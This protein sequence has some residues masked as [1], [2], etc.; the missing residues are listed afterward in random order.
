MAHIIN[1]PPSDIYFTILGEERCATQ[2]LS[3]LDWPSQ[4]AITRRKRQFE[5]YQK[6]ILGDVFADFIRLQLGALDYQDERYD[7]YAFCLIFTPDNPFKNRTLAVNTIIAWWQRWVNE[8][9]YLQCQGS[10]S[11]GLTYLVSV[12]FTGSEARYWQSLLIVMFVTRY[13]L[14]PV[15]P[16][17]IYMP[18]YEDVLRI[19]SDAVVHWG[20]MPERFKSELGEKTGL[21]GIELQD[22]IDDYIYTGIMA[23]RLDLFVELLYQQQA[24]RNKN[25]AKF[26]TYLTLGMAALIALP[27]IITASQLAYSAVMSPSLGT[28]STLSKIKLGI[29]VFAGSLQLAFKGLLMAIHFDTLIKIHKVAWLVSEDYRIVMRGIYSELSAISQALGF[30]PYY[31]TLLLQNVRMLVLDVASTF[32]MKADL[33]E[34]QWLTTMQGYLGRFAKATTRYANNPEAIFFDLNRWVEKDLVDKKGEFMQGLILTVERATEA[35]GG[36]IENVVV[37]RNDIDRLVLDLPE[38][39]RSQVEPLVRPYLKEFDDFI[40]TTYDPYKKQLDN[41][42]SNVKAIQDQQVNNMGLLVDRLKKPGDYL[43][44]IDRLEPWE[45]VSQERKIGDIST[46]QYTRDVSELVEKGKPVS[47]ELAKIREALKLVTL[48]PLGF[49]EE[50][51]APIRSSK[52]KATPRKTWFIGDY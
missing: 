11:P 20:Q 32:G 15:L 6:G 14:G 19:N 28:L 42:I 38:N 50:I 22:K 17:G 1:D 48:V 51:E 39:I 23:L 44:E 26:R 5:Y 12:G 4:E 47:A 3:V 13:G 40:L 9:V 31:L 49:P 29:E 36:V 24:E 21:K 43:S 25:I 30:G 2:D 33:A 37:I 35:V 7:R 52:V 41:I 46:R 18:S 27:A 16:G 45:R 8:V 10:S 34:V